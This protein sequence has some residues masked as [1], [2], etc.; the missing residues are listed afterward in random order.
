[1]LITL[2]CIEVIIE[3]HNTFDCPVKL[4]CLTLTRKAIKYSLYFEC[5]AR[6]RIEF[7]MN[8]CNIYV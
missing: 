8:I 6:I 4:L 7:K 2:F 5:C 3:D 1:M